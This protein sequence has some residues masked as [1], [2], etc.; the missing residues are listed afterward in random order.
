MR[1]LRIALWNANGLMKHKLELE[2]FLKLYDIQIIL[3]SE[4]HF[5]VKNYFKIFGYK[6]Y[7]TNHPSGRA[8]GGTAILV[9][10]NIRH[11]ELAPYKQDHL[12]ATSVMIYDWHCPIAISAV[13]SP[14]RHTIKKE[15]FDNFFESLD[16]RFLAGGD[17]NA[18]H[19]I[20]GSR[21]ITPR[22]RELSKSIETNRLSCIS[23]GE[24][25]YWPTDVN[26][27]P[28]LLDFFIAKNLSPRYIQVCSSFDLSSDHTPI[29]AT[30][31]T[32]II[33]KKPPISLY[34]RLTNWD[35]FRETFCLAI[36]TLLE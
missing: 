20:W 5:T 23:S 34:N 8:H 14:P 28:D 4:T 6:V 26:K 22:G 1:T 13:Y 9:K 18:K 35:F 2:A 21:I 17:Y 3:I 7:S 24:P 25:T 12:Q 16:S 36:F 15:D 19:N 27:I 31:N 11:Y 32:T 30:I 33:D 10:S 29:I